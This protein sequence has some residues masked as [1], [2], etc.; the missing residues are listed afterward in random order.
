MGDNLHSNHHMV[1]I[2]NILGTSLVTV[3]KHQTRYKLQKE[4][5]TL[6]HGLRMEKACQW[7]LFTSGQMRKQ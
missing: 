1:N 2:M 3:T 4:E 5:F 6:V 7:W